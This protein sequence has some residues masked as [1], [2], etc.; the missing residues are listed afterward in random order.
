M[1]NITIGKESIYPNVGV[2]ISEGYEGIVISFF[3]HILVNDY[4]TKIESHFTSHREEIN[5]STILSCLDIL[6]N[7]ARTL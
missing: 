5:I 7:K 4:P 1:R 2:N 6:N 3:T